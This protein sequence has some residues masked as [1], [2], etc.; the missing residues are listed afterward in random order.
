MS[1]TGDKY[2]A[3]NT[4]RR[5][6]RP[7]GPFASSLLA[8]PALWIDPLDR[9]TLTL[10]RAAHFGAADNHL[11]A[12]DHD[13][14]DF[15]SVQKFSLEFWINRSIRQNDSN[16]IDDGYIGQYDSGTDASWAVESGGSVNQ[17]TSVRFFAATNASGSTAASV[18]TP[19]SG[20]EWSH[21]VVTYDGTQATDTDRVRIYLDGAL[22]TP[23]NYVYNGTIPSSVNNSAADMTI[24]LGRSNH[25]TADAAISRARLW[26]NRILD[27][28]AASDLYN[29]GAGYLHADLPAGL[30]TSMV[31]S[32][33]LTEASGSS[34]A[35][36]VG[37]H[38]LAETGGDVEHV[39][40]VTKLREK[41]PNRYEFIPIRRGAGPFTFALCGAPR[42]L[43][44]G[45]G[46]HG[47]LDFRSS[48]GMYV[49]V[50][51]ALDF[52][53]YDY[54]AAMRYES[55]ADSESFLLVSADE[56]STVAYWFP[57]EVDESSTHYAR[58]RYRDENSD[59]FNTNVKSDIALA[60][61]TSY[62]SNWRAFGTGD[63]SSHEHRLNGTA[64]SLTHATGSQN[65]SLDDVEG[66]DNLS[67]G[68]LVRSDGN[69]TQQ[70]KRILLGEILVYDGSTDQLTA[71]ENLLAEEYIAAGAGVTLA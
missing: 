62:V 30:L 22:S 52:S 36:S 10:L 3:W 25:G 65:L 31:A 9:R 64:S 56:G 14:F 39:D 1:A 57:G 6:V 13:D 37:S 42:W 20:P 54:I 61:S 19:T 23:A 8:A 11:A 49:A 24:G 16:G 46:G 27:A 51:Q 66:R 60:T 34:R 68:C 69:S 40:L 53:A 32:W 7:L 17:A 48:H 29:S 59:T 2:T 21:C 45:L 18:T 50:D 26:K 55:F 71:A 70:G 35:D 44:T 12:S 47:V 28:T 63:A 15:S 33:D 67:L 58:L 43:E 41:G 38:T 4:M 5:R